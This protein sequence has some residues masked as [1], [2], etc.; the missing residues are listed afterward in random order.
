MKAKENPRVVIGRRQ[1][2]RET[3]FE[4]GKEGPCRGLEEGKEETSE[5]E[6]RGRLGEN[7]GRRRQTG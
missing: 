7:G 4:Y 5:S 3:G 6:R 2:L 1:F